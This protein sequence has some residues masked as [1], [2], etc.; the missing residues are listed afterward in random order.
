MKIAINFALKSGISTTNIEFSKSFIVNKKAK[1]L[2]FK[3]SITP[4]INEDKRT[5]VVVLMDII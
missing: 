5:A 3:M 2:W 1:E 4:M